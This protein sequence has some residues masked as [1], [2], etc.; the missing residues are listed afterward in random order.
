MTLPVSVP[1]DGN[2]KVLWVT[3][4]SDTSAPT[5]AELTAASVVDLSCYITGGGFQNSLDE[6]EIEDDRLCSRQTFSQPGKF[7]HGLTLMYVH[8]PTSSANNKAY[9]T[10][11]YKTTGYVVVRY[12]V[13]YDTAIDTAD[14][15]DVYPAKCGKQLKVPGENNSVHKVSQK[16]FITAEVEEDA[17]VA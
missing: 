4:I 11:T 6:S 14:I 17:S 9:T 8:N 10:L 16:I 3:T 7:K 5:K 13:A 2:Q 12:G 15:V 1:V